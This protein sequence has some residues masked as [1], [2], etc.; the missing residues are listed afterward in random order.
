MKVLIV[1]NCYRL[2]GGEDVVARREAEL[3]RS[4]GHDVTYYTRSN[5][6]LD[7]AGLVDRASASIAAIWS[8]KSYAELV[9]LLRAETP[10]VVHVHNAHFVISPAVYFACNAAGVPVVQTLHNPRLMCPAGTLSRNGQLC[11]EC[12]GRRFA[13]PGVVHACYRDSRAATALTAAVS[14]VHRLLGT[15]RDRIDLYIASTEFY[16]RLFIRC[17]LPAEKVVVKPHFVTPDPGATGPVDHGYALFIGRLTSE[18]GIATL[19]EAWRALPDVPLKI[20]GDGPMMSSVAETI[21]Q[22]GGAGI[23]VVARLDER[24]LVSLIRG[25]AFLVWPSI[26]FYETFGLVAIEAFA[27]GRPVIASRVGVMSEIVEDGVTG[28]H[29]EA[30]DAG[31]LV[32]KVRWAVDHSAE[33]QRMGETARQ[34]FLE[35]YT[36][37]ANHS[38]LAQIYELARVRGAPRRGRNRGRWRV[39]S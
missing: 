10:D 38:K 6:E 7:A 15:W 18:K 16:R 28:L 39:T 31:D 30:G 35:R 19:L 26:G 34:R 1:H 5:E 13:I 3:L 14:S 17:G 21:D 36:A 8:R 12:V 25:A 22:N 33:M 32:R 37:E 11:T 20:R 23:E 24:E 2:P 9:D 27:C 4:H 29:F